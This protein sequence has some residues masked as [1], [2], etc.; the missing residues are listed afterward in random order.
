MLFCLLLSLFLFGSRSWFF[1]PHKKKETRKKYSK[2]FSRDWRNWRIIRLNF[3]FYYFLLL[4]FAMCN[5]YILFLYFWIFLCLLLL[6]FFSGAERTKKRRFTT[7]AFAV[8][9]HTNFRIFHQRENYME[10]LSNGAPLHK[11]FTNGFVCT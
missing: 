1:S 2:R 5:L 3:L 8:A 7:V 11:R 9:L 6:F 4:R 10:N